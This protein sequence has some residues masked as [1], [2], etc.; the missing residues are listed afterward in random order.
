MNYTQIDGQKKNKQNKLPLWW[1]ILFSTLYHYVEHRQSHCR[2]EK[3]RAILSKRN[4]L[5]NFL[6]TWTSLSQHTLLCILKYQVLRDKAIIALL[7]EHTSAIRDHTY[8]PFIITFSAIAN[9]SK[10]DSQLCKAIAHTEPYFP[11]F[12]F[13]IFLSKCWKKNN[14]RYFC[15][16]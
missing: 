7:Q 4:M 3:L 6:H 5:Q 14:K 10:S 1:Q 8:D 16:Y 9:I 15:K 13:I 11:E 2:K 12:N